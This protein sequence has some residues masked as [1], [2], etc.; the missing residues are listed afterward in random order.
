MGANRHAPRLTAF[1]PQI[2]HWYR[3]RIGDFAVAVISDGPF[4]LGRP[5]DNFQGLAPDR[6]RRLLESHFLPTHE[7]VFEQNALLVDTG[8]D[9][10]LFDTGMGTERLLGPDTGHLATNMA[11]AGINPAQVTAVALTHAHVDHC[12]GMI[13]A[14]GGAAFPNATVY[15]SRHDF[16]EWTDPQRLGETGLVPALVT[17]AR[18]QLL[19]LGDR[20]VFIRDGEELVPGVTAL[21]T[22]GHTRGHMAYVVCSRNE[23]LIV[24]GDLFHHQIVLLSHPRLE[25]TYDSDPEQAVRSRL[26][27][28]DQVATDRLA[29]L[30]YHFPFPG[31]GHVSR[32]ADGYRWH[33]S[34]LRQAL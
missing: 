20:L 24:T 7:V 32:E 18:R 12:S 21:A 29:V 33:Q 4:S 23:T 3:F 30:S 31:L 16:E 6:L 10:V 8:R 9:L 25:F 14:G 26:R 13:D 27:I 34:P 5:E 2:P 17:A 22:P 19:P 28:L 11:A 15:L 1:N